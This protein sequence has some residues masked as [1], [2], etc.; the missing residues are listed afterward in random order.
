MKVTNDAE[1]TDTAGFDSHIQI[2]THH[3][4]PHPILPVISTPMLNLDAKLHLGESGGS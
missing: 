1:A 2:A 4:Q 3:S